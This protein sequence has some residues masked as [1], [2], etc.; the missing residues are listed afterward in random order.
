MQS[1]LHQLFGLPNTLGVSFFDCFANGVDCLQAC[2]RIAQHQI[3][4]NRFGPDA[5]FHQTICATF[6][7]QP[8]PACTI[9]FLQCLI[10][11]QRTGL[12]A[13][14][15]RICRRPESGLAAIVSHSTVIRDVLGQQARRVDVIFRLMRTPS[16]PEMRFI[17]LVGLRELANQL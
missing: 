9:T 7:V 13:G 8:E 3:R 10:D 1:D 4:I 16:Q 17:S 15:F 14:L 12:I 2:D 11:H 6:C 5:F